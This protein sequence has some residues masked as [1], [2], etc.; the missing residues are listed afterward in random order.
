MAFN[1]KNNAIFFLE[2]EGPA[3]IIRWNNTP[4]VN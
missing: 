4:P 1:E 3:L 2:D